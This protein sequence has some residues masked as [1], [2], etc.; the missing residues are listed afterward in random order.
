MFNMDF[1]FNTEQ[2]QN[3]QCQTNL[4]KAVGLDNFLP[5]GCPMLLGVVCYFG[6]MSAETRLKACTISTIL[7]RK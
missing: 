7:Y 6:Q 1:M 2:A 4:W 3:L 5:S